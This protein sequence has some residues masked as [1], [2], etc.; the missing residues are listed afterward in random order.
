MDARTATPA[1]TRYLSH[2]ELVHRPGERQLANDFLALLGIDLEDAMGGRFM[3]AVVDKE[4]YVPQDFEN[5]FG[6]SEVHSEQWAFEEALIE[7]IGEGGKLGERFADY[8]T[9]LDRDPTSGMHIGIHY[10]EIPEWEATVA[11][12][13]GLE[14]AFPDLKNRVRIASLTRPGDPGSFPPLYQCFVWTDIISAGS[15]AI[16]QRWE[17]SAIDPEYAP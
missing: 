3:M 5:F 8:Q 2:A 16:G 11:R 9:R 1:R 15:L 6:G 17:L 13:Q 12:L 14:Q 4:S 10:P 7:A